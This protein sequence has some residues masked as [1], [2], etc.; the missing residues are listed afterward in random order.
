MIGAIQREQIPLQSDTSLVD[1][2]MQ[3]IPPNYEAVMRHKF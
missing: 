1:Q 3:L 2:S